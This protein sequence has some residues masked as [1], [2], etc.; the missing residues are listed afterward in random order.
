MDGFF[1]I[2]VDYGGT[3]PREEWENDFREIS[4]TGFNYVRVIAG[5]RTP[6]EL[7]YILDLAGKWDVGVLV[8]L[9]H[10]ILAGEEEPRDL[11]DKSFRQEVEANLYRPV[12]ERLSERRSVMAWVIPIEDRILEMREGVESLDWQITTVGLLDPSR[13]VVKEATHP[14]I[15][16]HKLPKLAGP[17][18]VP[19]RIQV[20]LAWAP[21][22][23]ERYI[24]S[25]LRTAA[26]ASGS[27]DLWAMHLQAGP[28]WDRM[29]FG[30]NDA[31]MVFWSC[32]A[33]G[34]K[35]LVFDRW[36]PGPEPNRYG[37]IKNVNGHI[38]HGLKRMAA[39]IRRLN[40]LPGLLIGTPAPPAAAILRAKAELAALP[41][42][43]WSQGA[44]RL[45]ADN[46]VSTSFVFVDD[47][48]SIKELREYSVVYVPFLPR[49]SRQ[50]ADTLAEYVRTG[51]A[52]IAEAPF[53][54]EDEDGRPYAE[55]PGAGLG[56]VFGCKS[57]GVIPHGPRPVATTSIAQGVF[58]YVGANSRFFIEAPTEDLEVEA[59]RS[60]IL[61]FLDPRTLRATGPAAVIGKFGEGKTAY[62]AGNFSEAYRFSESWYARELMSGVLDWM[63][64]RRQAEVSGLTK[65]FENEFEVGIIQGIDD[66]NRRAFICI[67]HSDMNVHPTLTAPPGPESV[68]RELFTNSEVQA[69]LS[70]GELTLMTHVPQ[71][72]VRIYY[73][74]S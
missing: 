23:G 52:L 16:V 30:P 13:A 48:A 7:D 57:R 56:E 62:F 28:S 19:C 12:I 33:N 42:H 11:S 8:T 4:E 74:R 55:A 50:F 61:D 21:W 47:Q 34:A 72:E 5:Q 49:C 66:A 39:D 22:Q 64:T 54:I 31:A 25:V 45:L 37:S 43:K 18:G 53:A 6:D 44:Y 29:Y 26:G 68:I 59:G 35:G 60:A 17:V 46:F 65:G 10:R 40:E 70:G 9:D 1:P 14:P 63:E 20:P 71:R 38:W 58:T 41:L 51:G 3:L 15:G 36:D 67:N 2:G 69:Q 24:G 73:E 32:I 27:A